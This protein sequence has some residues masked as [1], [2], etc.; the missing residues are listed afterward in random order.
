MVLD[1][2]VV[3]ASQSIDAALVQQSHG[4]W[5]GQALGT[6]A[7]EVARAA[8]EAE[9]A[10]SA[11]SHSEFHTR[12]PQCQWEKHRS[13]FRQLSAYVDA[14][15]FLE[16]AAVAVSP[17]SRF[18]L[19]CKLCARLARDAPGAA[20]GGKRNKWATFNV[21][22]YPGV[23]VDG[24]QKHLQTAMHKTTLRPCGLMRHRRQ[25]RRLRELVLRQ[26]RRPRRS[27]SARHELLERT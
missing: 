27:W 10:R 24:V 17:S 4:A 8:A 20:T 23:S 26:A 9:D 14:A 5:V 3:Q 13:K 25:A 22:D 12:C 21:C 19:G 16:D 15:T 7:A 6:A 11:C 1:L 2:G 18:A